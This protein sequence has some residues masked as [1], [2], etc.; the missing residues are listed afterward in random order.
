[1]PLAIK[2]KQCAGVTHFDV[3]ALKHDAHL[4]FERQ[5]A[6]EVG[7]CC[8][9]FAHGFGY[10]LLGEVEFLLQAG[11]GVGLLNRV[12]I[13]ALD[14]LD[15]RHGNGGLIGDIPHQGGHLVEASHLGGAPA[16]FPG[17]DFVAVWS[18]RTHH[19]GL[20]DALA[21]D[22]LGQLLEGFRV[23]IAAR[24]VFATLEK[25]YR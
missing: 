9:G 11:E 25:F 7:H 3:T 18:Q 2:A 15:Q 13:L 16:T 14:I 17:D 20:H 23:H 1:L 21:A 22:R 12:E 4:V 8:A 19:N 10:L 24:L 5:Q 6:H